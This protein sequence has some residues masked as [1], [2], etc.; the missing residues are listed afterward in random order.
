[1]KPPLRKLPFLVA[2][3][4]AVLGQGAHGETTLP[5]V[6]VKAKA[7]PADTYE[8]T[9]T[10]TATKIDVPLR[11]VPQTV[12]AVPKTVM[13]DQNA[14]SVQDALQNVPSLSFSVGDGQRDQV[15]IRGFSAINDQFVDG[16][17]DDALYFRDLSNIERIEV[18]KGPAS[19]LY[20][21]GSAGGLINRVSKKPTPDPVMEVGATIGS[22]G[23]KRGE[24]DLGTANANKDKLFRITG[25]LEDSAG[26]RNQYFLERQ[27]LAPSATFR[28]QSATTLTL[29]ADYLKDKRLADQ[30][31]PSFRGRP[32]AAPIETYYGAANGRDRAFVQSEVSSGTA[33]LDHAFNDSLKLHSVLRTYDFSLDR[34]YTTIARVTNGAAPTVTIS[35]AHRTRDED[36]Y[37]W[38][39]EL[40]QKIQW[41]SMRHNVLYGLELGKQHKDEVLTT[42]NNVA[43]YDLFKPVLATLSPIPATI[44]PSNNNKNRIGITG[45]YLQDLVTLNPQWKVLSGVR[46][47]KLEQE[48]D[49]LTSKNQDLKRTDNTWSPRVGAVYQPTE[50]VSL[51]AG[52]SKSFQ[53][54]ADSFTFKNNSDQLKP[55]ETKST[56]VG[57]KFDINTKASFTAALFEMS[58]TNIQVADPANANLALPIGK[59]RTRGIELS[60]AGEV[61]P[62]WEML[63]GYSFMRGIITESTERTSAGTPFQ[64]NT[65]ALTPKHTFNFWVKRKFDNGYYVAAGGRAES[66]RYASPDNQTVLPGYAVLNLGAGYQKQKYDVAVTLKNLLNRTYYVSAHSGAN[67]YNMPGGPRSLLVSARYRF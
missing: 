58:Q 17:R 42:R 11:D 41:G 56:E 36:G 19:V 31:V 57:A 14:L 8:V 54:I 37:Y 26:F 45:V 39:N 13:R 48:R 24:F 28:L 16:V 34:N 61:A 4:C 65:A 21:R 3:A 18:L 23:Q 27:A 33:T 5:A 32:V 10:T 6:V 25:A 53:P 35:Q 9:H 1:M 64:G 38:Q 51:Y 50:A 20:G 49:D 7:E 62:R 60:F 67:D 55:T 47:D 43:T 66:A 22:E 44:A 46:Y 30:G 52:Y 63:A 15:T 29:Q 2:A 59:Q 40:T 12:N